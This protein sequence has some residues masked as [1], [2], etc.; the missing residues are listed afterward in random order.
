MRTRVLSVRRGAAT[1]ASAAALVALSACT[2]GSGT[3]TGSPSPSAAGKPTT[4]TGDSNEMAWLTPQQI[5]DKSRAANARA[6]SYRER[7][8]RADANTNLLLSA[9]EC[10][11]TVELTGLGTFDVIMKNRDIW[12]KLDQALSK[13]A[14]EQGAVTVPAE[15]WLHGTPEHPL[16]GKLASWCQ[17]D[18]VSKPDTVSAKP[19]AQLMRG[20]ITTLEDGRQAIPVTVETSSTSVTW[21][22]ATIGTPYLLRQDAARAGMEDITYSDFGTPVNATAP[23][24]N[25]EEAPIGS[26]PNSN[27]H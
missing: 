14:S 6:G 12:A 22:A 24:G 9:S 10:S 26:W 18:K 20:D 7:M 3:G 19:S 16:M 25:V 11:G 8:T 2:D 23:P 5:Y 21:Y 1:L 17:T 27:L 4:L 15:A 13:W